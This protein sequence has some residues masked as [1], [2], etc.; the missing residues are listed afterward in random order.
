MLAFI[1]NGP[2]DAKR[3]AAFMYNAGPPTEPAKP[4]GNNGMFSSTAITPAA[5][6]TA[7]MFQ[8]PPTCKLGY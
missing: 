7:S 3:T 2:S 6:T 4:A 8:A 5:S 1:E